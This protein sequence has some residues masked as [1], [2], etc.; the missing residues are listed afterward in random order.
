MVPLGLLNHLYIKDLFWVV[1]WWP[2]AEIETHEVVRYL[3]PDCCDS[4]YGA[5]TR[6]FWR[7]D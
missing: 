6:Q 2:R 7:F 4:F 1:I 5:V 3:L